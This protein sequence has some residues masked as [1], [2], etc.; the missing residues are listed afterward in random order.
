MPLYILEG[1]IGAGKSTLISR[2]KEQAFPFDHVVVQEPV[3]LWM[4]M[5]DSTGTSVIEKYYAD[6]PK[7]GFTFQMFIL[8]TRVK[9]ILD[10]VRDH[11]DKVVFCERSF[12]TDINIFAK[13][14]FEGGVL[15]EIEWRV[16][17]H[18]FD[19]ITSE[20][21]IM[22]DGI[23]YLR[24]EPE[25]CLQ[26]I[27]G[28]GRDGEGSIGLEYLRGLHDAHEAW[29]GKTTLPSMTIDGNNDL[30]IDAFWR[31]VM[32]RVGQFVQE[33]SS[34]AGDGRACPPQAK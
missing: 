18:V 2:L 10:A 6:M 17:Q 25:V 4:R 19:F 15:E 34:G 1:Q 20:I 26:R 33:T 29:I 30:S 23:L 14:M 22:I 16:F 21:R 12:L 11:P 28:R 3:D 24:C 5:K 8:A 32:V 31:D 13:G 7:Y 27:R 9:C